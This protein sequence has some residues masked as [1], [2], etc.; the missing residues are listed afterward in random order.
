MNQANKSGEQDASFSKKRSINHKREGTLACEN[1]YIVW[2][3]L[4]AR[5]KSYNGIHCR[6]E[7][8]ATTA[9]TVN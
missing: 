2:Y 3:T 6:I 8:E 4:S 9:Q 5:S 1:M 7:L